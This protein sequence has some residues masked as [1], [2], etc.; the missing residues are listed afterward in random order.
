MAQTAAEAPAAP[1][2]ATAFAATGAAKV[3]AEVAT[4]RANLTAV[5]NFSL[6]SLTRIF[7]HMSEGAQL[8]IFAEFHESPVPRLRPRP[9]NPEPPL[10]RAAPAHQLTAPVHLLVRALV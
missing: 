7:A 10:R 3:A 2:G 1:A 8:A 9:T 4:I 5:R 6:E